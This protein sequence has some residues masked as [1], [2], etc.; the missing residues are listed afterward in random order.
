MF[1]RSISR[2]I[3][4]LVKTHISETIRFGASEPAAPTIVSHPSDVTIYETEQ[5]SFTVLASGVPSP[6]YQWEASTDGG[7]T[8]SDIFGETA[9]TLTTGPA[10]LSGNGYQ[11]RCVVTNSEGSVTSNP[12]TLTV[13]A[14]VPVSFTTH[15]SSTTVDPG[16]TATFTSVATGDP[17]PS[18]QWLLSTDG[19]ST[20]SNIAGATSANYTTPVLDIT[21]DGNQY[22]C[23]A[24]NAAGSNFSLANSNI[25]TLTVNTPVAPTITVQ[26][27]DQSSAVDGT[28]TFS[29]T[30]T[31][32][33]SPTY[34]WQLS[35]DGGSTY[36]NISG[37]TSDSYTTPTLVIGDDGNFY[38]CLVSNS[39]GSVFS[40]AVELTVTNFSPAN[41]SGIL[42]YSL[43]S[44]ETY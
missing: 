42:Q 16:D 2:P 33:P 3:R 32:V 6:T 11:Y 44:G 41:L 7:A 22:R 20:F 17:A 1:R 43:D 15:P 39:E 25:A 28:A 14:F 19:G 26:P 10:P 38:R 30:A 9:A 21:D 18:Y 27:T 4:W 36:G 37:A 34:Q 24:S 13:T 23:K 35:T 12:A 5:A 31:G 40:V 8:W 29:L